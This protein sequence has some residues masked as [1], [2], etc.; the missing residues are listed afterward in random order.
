M[1][2]V[3][4]KDEEVDMIKQ[5]G[6]GMIRMDMVWEAVEK[7]QSEYDFSGYRRLTDALA[8]REIVPI[9][10]LDYSH[11]LYEKS[12]SVRTPEGRQA[13]ARFAAEAVKT[14]SG[15]KIVWEIWN[16][17]N[18]KQ[19]W[20]EQ[21][22]FGD[23]V[24]L[25]EEAAKAMRAA[26]P[27]CTIIAPATSRIPLDFLEACFERGLLK[28][29]DAVSVHPYR[30]KN[31]E[32]ALDEYAALR[33]MMERYPEGKTMPIL[34]G[35]WGYSLYPYKNNN[36]DERRQAQYLVRQFLTNFLA[37][38]RLSIWYDWHDDGTDPKEKEHNFGAVRNDYQPKE[39][40]RAAKTFLQQFHGMK[41]IERM[42]SESAE[43]FLLIFGN[44]NNRMMA[45]WTMGAS[46]TIPLK[47]PKTGMESVSMLGEKIQL[48]QEG[49][50]VVIPLSESPVYIP[51]Q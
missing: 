8:Q 34:S 2:F 36:I 13:F 43:D 9:Y 33:R 14:F 23:Y 1:H 39:A 3:E 7:K 19:F 24:L 47:S 12:Q 35:E 45:A 11:K 16:E 38:V 25:A 6:F 21:P 42:A 37:D 49:E 17:P 27:E 18:I 4:P 41:F 20:E 22:S 50:G 51:L 44:D 5:A 32:S 46:H 28:W 26:D 31:P 40:Y 15:A 10:I 29:I 30:E 48:L